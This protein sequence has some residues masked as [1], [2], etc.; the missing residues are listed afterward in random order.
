M[1]AILQS[2]MSLKPFTNDLTTK[3]L[4][5]YAAKQ[6]D[7][8]AFFRAL[9]SLLNELSKERH[10]VL[11]AHR[12]KDSI[13][14]YSSRFAGYSQ[15]VYIYKRNLVISLYVIIMIVSNYLFNL[16]CKDA[17]EF[18]CACL[19]QLE[20]DIGPY[21]KEQQTKEKKQILV[22]HFSLIHSVL[23]INILYS[24]KM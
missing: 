3:S 13:G 19:D 16:Y 11:S 6:L 7:S 20:R 17:H 1:N 2:L 9:L 15:Q 22:L 8:T 23:H 24:S 18:L 4:F 21:I 10:G 14:K 12:I 5:T